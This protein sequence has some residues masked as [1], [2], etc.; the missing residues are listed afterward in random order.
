MNSKLG[1]I[2]GR[3]A[4]ILNARELVINIGSDQGVSRGMKFSVL[5]EAPMEI[6]DPTTNEVLDEIDREKVRVEASEV[7][8]R[9]TICRTFRTTKIGGKGL[10]SI[11][12]LSGLSFEALYGM[13]PERTVVE[14]LRVQDSQLPPPLKPEESYVKLNDRVV[15]VDEGTQD[16]S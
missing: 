12:A 8:N 9:I 2:E 14:T 5:S 4:Q 16:K 1:K 7:R 13:Q 15:S 11:A 6:R 10:Q 3:V